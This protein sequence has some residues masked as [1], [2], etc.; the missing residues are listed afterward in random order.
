MNDSD[1]E[2]NYGVPPLHFA[3]VSGHLKKPQMENI[4]P[5]NNF[6]EPQLHSAA[7]SGQIEDINP[8]NNHGDPPLHSAA[9][10]G[11]MEDINPENNRGD[12]PL[13]S[14]DTRVSNFTSLKILT[15]NVSGLK[16]YGRIDQVRN[17][18][19]KHKIDVAVLTE[20]E[21]SHGM[22]KTFNIDG[23]KVFCPPHFTTGPRG[24]EAGVITLVANDIAIYAIERPDLNNKEDTIPTVWIQ[25]KNTKAGLNCIIGGVYRRNR[26]STDEVK[27]EFLQLQQ[28]FLGAAQSNKTVLVLGDINVDHNNPNHKLAK[29][30]KDLLAVV[31]AANMRHLPNQVPTWKSH[32]FHKMCKCSTRLCGCQRL[33][34]TSCIDNA[35]VSI[36]TKSSLNVLDEAITDHFP[37]IIQIQTNRVVK[38][39][40]KSIWIR[41]VPGMSDFE[42]ENALG[43]QEWSSIYETNDPNEVFKTI[44]ANVNSSL[45]IV[46]PLKEIKVRRDKTKLSLR[47]DT[48][49]TMEARNNARK[50][51]NKSLYKLLRNKVTKLV[52]R[53][54]IQG[55]LSRLGKNPGPKSSWSEAKAYLGSAR[56]NALPET[57]TNTDPLKTAEYQN[58]YFIKKIEKLAAS[59]SRSDTGPLPSPTDTSTNTKIKLQPWPSDF[60]GSFENNYGKPPLHS[61]AE[62]GHLKDSNPKKD[63]TEDPSLKSSGTFEFNFVNASQIT[64]KI[65]NLKNTKALGVDNIATEVWKKGR[66][67]LSGPIARLCNVS[68]ATG[69]HPELFK[70]AIIHPVYKGQGKDPRDPASYRPVAILPAISK[71]LEDVVRDSLLSWFKEINFLPDTQYGFQPGKSVAMALT[72]AQTD[73]INSKARGELIG[74]MAFDLSAAF[75]T[76]EHSLLLRKLESAN[77]K[78]IPLKW[79][80]SYLSGRSQC[81]LWNNTLS[82]YLPLN[83]GVPQG[84][85]LGPILFLVMIQDMPG[86]LTRNTG[87]TSSTVVGY[88]D[89]TTVYVKAKDPEHLRMELQSLGNIMVDYCDKNGLVLNG[90]KTQLLSNARKKFEI[91]INHDIVNSNP[92]ISLLGLEYDSNFST[93]PYLRK[94]AR[95]ANTRAA[96]IKRL[97]FGMPNYLLK[98]LANGLLMGKILAAAPAA[99]PIRIDTKDRPYLAGVLDDIDK[100][101]KYSARTITRTK[102]TDK[103]R[104]EITLWKAGLKSLTEAV[105]ITMATLVWKARKDMDTLGF[106][107]EKKPSI[108]DTRSKFNDKLCQTVLEHPQLTS[109]KMA[110][111]WNNLN[112]S[113]SKSIACTRASSAI[114]WYQNNLKISI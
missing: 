94:L 46:A 39:K 89:D 3:A 108:K 99:I 92:T 33:Q 67:T 15:L 59:T 69:I 20:T 88:A 103:V 60:K 98:P 34:H 19:V 49:A 70:K 58:E 37:L 80:Q 56:G 26:R 97:S 102:L 66:I 86:Y 41:D 72:V 73:W 21:I 106:I 11:Q 9:I 57:T 83:N 64:K 12:P 101:I 55:V 75:D 65:S 95:E 81:V 1:A 82:N 62:S 5:E 16:S 53:D 28:Q 17:L 71:V 93:A 100:A 32:G 112:L 29:E 42:F 91:N 13:H 38:T 104:S 84:S 77:V 36:D 24:K 43:L 2:N 40:L 22:A 54:Q 90:Q 85:I 79:F 111:I 8:E 25:L 61:A 44:L 45:D 105:S 10:S 74:I 109:N 31:E 50:S 87:T 27:K 110:Q 107:F 47:K 68:M 30:A 113:N 51:G 114:K 76:L 48:L 6:G 96:L 78:G 35:Y 23:Y 14:A 52:K 63:Y 4:T 7:I 18:L